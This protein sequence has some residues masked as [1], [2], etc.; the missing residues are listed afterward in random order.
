MRKNKVNYLYENRSENNMKK[1]N[2]KK[3]LSIAVV[4]VIILAIAGIFY[5]NNKSNK[6]SKTDASTEVTVNATVREAAFGS[7]V[8]VSLS[9]SGKKKYVGAVKYQVYYEGKP[10]TQKEVLGKPATAYPARKEND[11][12][13]IKL[14][15]ADGKDAY[16]VDL[17]LQKENIA[18]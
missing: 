4:L 3:T 6:S 1:S 9:D 15:T 5:M 7:V 16:S 12:V 17:N 13:T 10:V 8:N 11:K 2:N 18:K 14:A